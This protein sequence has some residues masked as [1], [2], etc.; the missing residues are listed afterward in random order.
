M[1]YLFQVVD[2]IP[3]EGFLITTQPREKQIVSLSGLSQLWPL[4][5]PLTLVG[6]C[7]VALGVRGTFLTGLSS[8][9]TLAC[10]PAHSLSTADYGVRLVAAFSLTS[11]YM[12]A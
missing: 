10:L 2:Q 7:E 8:L 9:P 12:S 1:V 5:V 11:K 3:A 4:Q 6:H